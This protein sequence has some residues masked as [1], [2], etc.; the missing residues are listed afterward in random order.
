MVTF[1]ASGEC[2]N[3]RSGYLA[4]PTLGLNVNDIKT[5]LIFLNNAVNSFVA[6]TSEMRGRVRKRATVPHA[7][8]QIEN[9]LLKELW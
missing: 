2:L 1:K 7:N 5:E 6:T 8:E 9:E 3:I 4:I